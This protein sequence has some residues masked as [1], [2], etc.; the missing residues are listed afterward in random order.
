MLLEAVQRHLQQVNS[1][2][3]SSTKRSQ[4]TKSNSY[5]SRLEMQPHAWPSLLVFSIAGVGRDS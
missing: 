3:A 1:M 2:D 5:E 4:T